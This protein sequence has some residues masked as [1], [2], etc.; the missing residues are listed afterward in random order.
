MAFDWRKMFGLKSSEA[1]PSKS[2]ARA[3]VVG[4]RTYEVGD[5]IGG[6][7]RVLDVFSGGMGLVYLVEHHREEDPFVL[8]TLQRPESEAE[9]AQFL[10]EAE[11]WLGLGRHRNIVRARFVTMLDGQRYVAAD[12]VPRTPDRSNTLQAYVGCRGLPTGLLLTWIVQF[13]HGM[14][15]AQS[16]GMVAHRDIKPGNLMLT[17][18]NELRITDFGLARSFSLPS[19]AIEG[20]TERQM[21]CWNSSLYGAGAVG[22]REGRSPR[23]YLRVWHHVV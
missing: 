17:P 23:R 9:V 10:R 14:A 20:V 13:C 7:Y 8:K 1:P 22:T 2:K 19:G 21:I 11:I 3:P 5:S 4:P 6:E 15:H 12:Y 16:H 18:D